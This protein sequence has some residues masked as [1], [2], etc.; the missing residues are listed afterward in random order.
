MERARLETPAAGA[1][2]GALPRLQDRPVVACA[3]ASIFGVPKSPG[4]GRCRRMRAGSGGRIRRPGPD[5]LAGS[6]GYPPQVEGGVRR[7]RAS[8]A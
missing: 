2:E 5:S 7:W 1:L 8:I 4:E 3:T 6:P